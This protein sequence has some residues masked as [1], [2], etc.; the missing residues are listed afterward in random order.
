VQ[1][2]SRALRILSSSQRISALRL[3]FKNQAEVVLVDNE[4]LAMVTSIFHNTSGEQWRTLGTGVWPRLVA[5]VTAKRGH[6]GVASEAGERA[7]DDV[8]VVQDG[9]AGLNGEED[10]GGRKRGQ[11]KPSHDEGKASQA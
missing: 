7:Q 4:P 1:K 10:A 2:K 11:N 9:Q 6:S 5:V 3:V 8:Q